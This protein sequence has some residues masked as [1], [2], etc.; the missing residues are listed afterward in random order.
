M[1]S[2]ESSTKFD[3]DISSGTGP[4]IPTRQDSDAF[5]PGRAATKRSNRRFA[6][7]PRFRHRLPIQLIEGLSGDCLLG[8]QPIDSQVWLSKSSGNPQPV[9][10][11]LISQVWQGLLAR[12][13]P[14]AKLGQ[15]VFL[16]N[17]LC[18]VRFCLVR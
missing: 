8:R 13:E 15:P 10:A 4:S 1:E 2:S 6:K 18:L 12:S 7:N 3:R 11:G 5:D 17:P 14:T 9:L 16:Q